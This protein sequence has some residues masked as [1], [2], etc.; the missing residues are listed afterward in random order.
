MT[1]MKDEDVSERE[2]KLNVSVHPRGRKNLH[3]LARMNVRCT[4]AF[5]IKKTKE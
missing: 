5:R 3:R 2:G 1:M 4:R